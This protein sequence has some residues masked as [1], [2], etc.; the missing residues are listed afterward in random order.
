VWLDAELTSPYAFYQFFLNTDDR[1][2][3]TYLRLFTDLTRAEIDELDAATRERPHERAAQRR[4]AEEFTALLHGR[5]EVDKVIAASQALFGRGSLADL[6]AETLR[7]A[8]EELPRAALPSAA[9][10]QGVA[11]TQ[12]AVDA[13]LCA[14]RSEARRA[15]EQ[16]GLYVNN[17]KVADEHAVLTPDHLL[18]GGVVLLRK[19]RRT[20]A[21]V[22]VAR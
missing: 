16:G 3:V 15:V 6:S 22:T 20:L 8:V 13:G 2:V 21:A 11:F 7:A 12:L 5:A 1:D 18:A 10:E 19:G 4:L 14:S 17:E 9:L